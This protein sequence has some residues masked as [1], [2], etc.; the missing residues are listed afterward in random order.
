MESCFYQIISINLY[1]WWGMVFVYLWHLHVYV[2]ACVHMCMHVE[3]RDQCQIS[4]S[5]TAHLI[6]ERWLSNQKIPGTFCPLSPA[7]VLEMWC[8]TPSSFKSVHFHLHLDLSRQIPVI[9]FLWRNL[10]NVRPNANFSW[11]DLVFVT[12]LFLQK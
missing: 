10:A 4:S 8:I 12:L 11:L 6:F 2:F 3:V 1:I 5:L 7:L 9:V